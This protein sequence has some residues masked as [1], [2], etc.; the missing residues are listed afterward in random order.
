MPAV[1]CGLRAWGLPPL[2][3]RRLGAAL[4]GLARSPNS[5]GRGKKEPKRDV[6][7]PHRQPWPGGPR[8]RGGEPREDQCT[9]RCSQSARV[10]LLLF[11]FIYFFVCAACRAW[12]ASHLIKTI[13]EGICV[14]QQLCALLSPWSR[15]A[16]APLPRCATG[17]GAG[18]TI[19]LFG[20]CSVL[21]L[22]PLC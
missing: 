7:E 6:G 11:F 17:S 21:C 9:A 2:H 19:L 8:W 20:T 16:V 13:T 15:A 10:L 3:R 14:L 4:A 1:G 12:L 18:N 22:Q 5:S